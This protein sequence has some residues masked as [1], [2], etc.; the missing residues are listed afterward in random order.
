MKKQKF[1]MSSAISLVLAVITTICLIYNVYFRE[2]IS[3]SEAIAIAKAHFAE[4]YGDTY[5]NE[6]YKL[7]VFD[8]EPL[9]YFQIG[10]INLSKPEGL[11]GEDPEVL[12]D[13]R[14]GKIIGSYLG[15]IEA[16]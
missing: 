15:N 14:T 13:I 7:V 2:P 9:G 1:I 8:F 12:I 4:E 16:P 3:E 6:N 5:F 11:D 10:F